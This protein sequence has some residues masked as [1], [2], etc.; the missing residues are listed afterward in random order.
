MLEPAFFRSSDNKTLGAD[1]GSLADRANSKWS[2]PSSSPRIETWALPTPDPYIRTVPPQQITKKR[3]SAERGSQ[4]AD[5]LPFG[6]LSAAAAVRL[7]GGPRP[8][9]VEVQGS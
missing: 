4:V 2:S 5:R 7:P 1:S 9:G 3:G 6:R 8:C